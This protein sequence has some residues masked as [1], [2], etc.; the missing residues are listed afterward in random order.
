MKRGLRIRFD[1]EFSPTAMRLLLV[2][3]LV[4][5]VASEVASESVTLTTYYPAPSGVY[6]QMITTGNTWLGRDG[7]TVSIG[8]N[9]AVGTRLT[10]MNGSVG[11]G[12]VSPGA[13]LSFNDVNDGS[14]GADGIT[15]YNPAPT[16]YG[17][18]RTAGAWVGPNYQQ[19]Q[20]SWQTGVVIDG[21]NAYGKSGTVL[22]PSGGNVG[23]G[24]APSATLDVNGT[25]VVHGCAG[26]A[27][28]N[29]AGDTSCPAGTYA[30]W[31]AG[32]MSR[33]QG[34][35]APGVG[36]AGSMLCCPCQGGVCPSL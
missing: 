30:T 8:Q 34:G 24:R 11:I 14:N 10:V 22:Q 23:I 20:L 19:L 1:V 12:T 25:I 18:Y 32:I 33:Y 17:I 26:V 21:G 16:A 4:F 15:W 28:F 27:V 7:G 5:S 29:Y 36:G 31:I 2:A 6:T 13:K 9:A 35:L 3:C